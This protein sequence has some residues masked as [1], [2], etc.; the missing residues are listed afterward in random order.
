MKST[1]HFTLNKPFLLKLTTESQRTSCPRLPVLGKKPSLTEKNDKR[2]FFHQNQLQTTTGVDELIV[3]QLSFW[4]Q[5]N[6]NYKSER[7]D[8]LFHYLSSYY[9]ENNLKGKLKEL[10]TL[11][12]IKK[13]SENINRAF[14]D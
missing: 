4:E 13:S 9:V 2:L 1:A 5:E 11:E 10:D 8:F 6:L 12:K 14:H 7:F 3:K